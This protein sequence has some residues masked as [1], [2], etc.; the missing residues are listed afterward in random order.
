MQDTRPGS[1][2][3]H[4]QDSSGGSLI[5]DGDTPWMTADLQLLRLQ[6]V[7]VGVGEVG[8]VEVELPADVGAE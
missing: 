3:F 8:A 1:G 4:H 7:P 6:G 5:T 2:V